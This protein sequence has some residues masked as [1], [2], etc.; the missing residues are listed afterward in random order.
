MK[1]KKKYDVDQKGVSE[2]RDSFLNAKRSRWILKKI[3]Y[4]LI[5][6]L[7][8]SVS[9]KYLHLKTQHMLN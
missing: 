8:N 4:R 3:Q 6:N 9:S 1:Q 7:F 2:K 5:L